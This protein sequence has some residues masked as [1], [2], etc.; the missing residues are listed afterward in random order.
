MIDYISVIKMGSHVKFI[1]LV[2]YVSGYVL[3]L[4]TPISLLALQIA[5]LT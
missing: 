1:Q 2:K 5:F 4:I 3:H